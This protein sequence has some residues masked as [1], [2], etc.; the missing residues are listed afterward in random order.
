MEQY[1]NCNLIQYSNFQK[2]ICGQ[3]HAQNDRLYSLL[4]DRTNA[5]EKLKHALVSTNQSGVYNLLI[6]A[7]PPRRLIEMSNFEAANNGNGVFRG[8]F[9]FRDVALRK[10]HLAEKQEID[11]VRDLCKLACHSH[12]ATLFHAEILD[13]GHHWLL[14]LENCNVSVE[15]YVRNKMKWPI[16]PENILQQ[17]ARGLQFLHRN[18]IVHKNIKPSN[19]LFVS[20]LNT[21]KLSN[22][23]IRRLRPTGIWKRWTPPDVLRQY[24]NPA[25]KHM[26]IFVSECLNSSPI[27]PKTPLL[28]INCLLISAY[29]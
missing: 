20:H 18:K 16:P 28:R 22:F 7:K 15:D 29:I 12:V 3:K 4:K 9:G 14:A 13:S 24:N 25:S 19:I 1:H 8:I 11:L 17:T 21:V 6:C 26:Y 27:V 2:H 23:G 10:L 5:Y